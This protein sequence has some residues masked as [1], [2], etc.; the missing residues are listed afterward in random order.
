MQ[1]RF[2][3]IRVQIDNRRFYTNFAVFKI[4]ICGTLFNCCLHENVVYYLYENESR[5][6]C[7][8]YDLRKWERF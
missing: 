3:L 5:Q 8:S 7:F 1:K 4:E 6:Y 2:M